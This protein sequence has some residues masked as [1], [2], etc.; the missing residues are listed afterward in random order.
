V[1]TNMV[2]VPIVPFPHVE[3]TLEGGKVYDAGAVGTGIVLFA[4]G[5]GAPL[6][7]GAVPS[8]ELGN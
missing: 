5:T 2:V 8:D 1:V 3:G 4:D 7:A 6:L